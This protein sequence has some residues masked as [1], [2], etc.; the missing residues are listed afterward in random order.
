MEIKAGLLNRSVNFVDVPRGGSG[1]RSRG[2]HTEFVASA[3][4]GGEYMNLYPPDQNEKIQEW[5]RG[6]GVRVNFKDG[7]P[8]VLCLKAAEHHQGHSLRKKSR[9]GQ[10]AHF[11]IPTAPFGKIDGTV[12][13]RVVESWVEGDEICVRI[14]SFYK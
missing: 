5:K 6:A 4:E 1:G 10:R 2:P 11:S 7:K 13:G 14:S 9:G 3:V 8:D 12:A